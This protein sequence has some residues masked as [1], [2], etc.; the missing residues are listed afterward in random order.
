[1]L[2]PFMI[3]KTNNRIVNNLKE[4]IEYADSWYFYSCVIMKITDYLELKP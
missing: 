3:L 2:V 4:A 1:L